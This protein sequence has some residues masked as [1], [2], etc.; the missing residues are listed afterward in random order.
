MFLPL[1]YQCCATA[2]QG[3]INKQLFNRKDKYYVKNKILL[4]CYKNIVSH[5][6]DY[7]SKFIHG[8]EWLAL[9]SE[10]SDCLNA[11]GMQFTEKLENLKKNIPTSLY[12]ISLYFIPFS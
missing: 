4:P 5:A 11:S 6:N 12:P 7:V 8:M 2:P 1:L 3:Y 9:I 10:Y